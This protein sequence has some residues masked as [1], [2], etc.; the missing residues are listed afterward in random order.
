MSFWAKE[1]CEYCHG[2]VEERAVELFKRKGGRRY[3]IRQVPAGVCRSCGARFFSA[4]VLKLI[5][6][7]LRH[8]AKPQLQLHVPVFDMN[9]LVHH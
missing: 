1:R 4:N 8:T 9:R 3:L 2:R 7:A 5:E 6:G